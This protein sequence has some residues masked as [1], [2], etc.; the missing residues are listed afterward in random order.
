MYSVDIDRKWQKKWDEMKLSSFDP[1]RLDKKLYVLEMFSYPSAA[2]LHVGHWFNYAPPDSWARM[3]KMR[4]YEVFQPIGFDAF[5][6]PAEN[7]AI[8]TGVH[9]EDSTWQNIET[10]TAQLKTL[11]GMFD[12]DA[13]LATCDPAYY[14]WNQ[15]LFL[16]LY[17]HGLA[18]RKNAL[19]NWCPS[20]KT[21]LANEQVLDDGTCE[22]CGTE[23]T[24]KAL[25]QW[26]FKITAYAD[27]LLDALP[28]LDWPETTKK[29]QTNWIGRSYGTEVAFLAELAGERVKNEDGSDLELR[30][31]TTRA[32]TL[33][34]TSYLVIAPESPLLERLTSD[35]Q[36][37]IVDDY[38]EQTKKA[39]EIARMSTTREKSGIFTGAFAIHP[40]TGE[41]LPLWTA[42]YV[43]ASYGT[44]VVM[45]VPAHDTR[46]FEFATT[47][48]L[49]II[50]VINNRQN[51]PQELPFTDYGV[52][53]D[54][55][56]FTGM[57]SA[58]AIAAMTAKLETMQMGK[59]VT[60]YRL[61]DWL[62]SRQRYWG[63]PIP[64][65]YCDHCGTVPVP[66][67]DLPVKLP[68]DVE[69]TPDGVSPLAKSEAF[70]NTTCPRCGGPA[71]RDADTLDTFVCSS[72]YQFRFV[73]NKNDKAPFDK[74]KVDAMCPV[75]MY[76]GGQEH[77]A[78]H[79]LYAR[80]I[81]KALRDMGHLDFDEP[82]QALVHQG[83]ILG[84]DGQKMSKS[85]GN[86]VSPDELVQA[87]GG[88][89]FRLH[90]LFSFAYT[91]GGNWNDDGLLAVSRFLTRVESLVERALALPKQKA[92]FD[93]ALDYRLHYT[94]RGVTQDTLRFQFNTSIARLMELLNHLQKDLA[95]ASSISEQAY[96][97]TL[98]LLQLLAPFAPHFAEEMWEQ[99]GHHDSIFRSTW[100]T[101]NEEALVLDEIEIAI[102]V[103]GQIKDRL[104][105]PND[106][107]QGDLETTVM[108][109]EQYA[110]WLAG[111]TPIKW[112]YV[113]GRLLNIVAK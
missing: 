10:M 79:L 113:K 81:T 88:D 28:T 72:W 61:R 14:R 22:R 106:I 51:E 54:S 65:V 47:F 75:D 27:Q 26:F 25:T 45:G 64:I 13:N 67:E 8:K 86:T 58:A 97:A 84:S 40:L 52:L 46:D 11:G 74:D 39:S 6:L 95:T 70:I 3:Q 102:Q 18:Y 109:H 69:F 7:Y 85:L 103:N 96:E 43:I 49:P 9:P 41:K 5:G 60:S 73:D 108:A 36:K 94:I 55:G 23:V 107:S 89:V 53:T 33:F 76:L 66:E 91:E 20:C 16:Q 21:V 1:R 80:F 105:I 48:E 4:G 44:G 110:S 111:R 100:P 31:F 98:T 78:M 63:T 50:N 17:K 59:S 32:D 87:H 37:P 24:K 35:A 99:T 30:V 112:I 62:V 83:M 19:V 29:I 82:F 56:A 57:D 92:A 71:K 42:D 2:K 34:G 77:A 68:Y 15:W 90:L 93:K 104:M 12:W 101:F 38:V